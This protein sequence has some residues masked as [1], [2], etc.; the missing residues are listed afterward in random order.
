MGFSRGE[1]VTML[2][3]GTLFILWGWY[4]FWD[5][6]YHDGKSGIQ[7]SWWERVAR[8]WGQLAIL[9]MSLLLL[10]STK[11]SI[12]MQALGITWER[13]LWM[14]RYLGGLC[15]LLMSLHILSYWARFT[16]LKS[17]PYDAFAY[18]QYYS[19]N[20]GLVNPPKPDYDNWTIAIMQLLAYPALFMVGI[21][22]LT[23]RKHWELFKYFHY[24]FLALIPALLLH[25][26]SAWYFLLGGIIFWLVDAAIRFTSVVS[27]AASLMPNGVRT[28]HT[29]GGIIELRM[30]W[31]HPEP[32]QFAWIKVPQV[33]TWEWHPFSLS[34]SPYDGCAQMCIKNMGPDT[35]TDRLYKLGNVASS[36]DIQIDG[37][38]GSP[39]DF[40]SHGALLLIAG[41]IGITQVHSLFRTVSHM[42]ERGV[43]FPVLRSVHI[44]W[45]AQSMDLFSVFHESIAENL[46]H[47]KVEF[48]ATFFCTQADSSEPQFDPN[49]ELK[50]GRPT[51]EHLYDS[52]ISKAGKSTALVQ[53]CGPDSMVLAAAEA[54]R[55]KERIVFDNAAFT[56]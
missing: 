35:F 17:F 49:I 50:T 43:E 18:I 28:H 56:L 11:N 5:H 10:P 16:E 45:I 31:V 42:V 20:H 54:A 34:S 19:I 41:G 25:S 39:P 12:W 33:S 23:R 52:A 48:G 21:S 29:E 30:N 2:L 27:T 7:D 24:V 14:H 47:T 40:G 51:F 22:S 37:P 15:L 38:Y 46:K 9:T 55:G 4:W 3:L 6:N 1:T 36:F 44:V 26:A 53:V 32:G 8:T 13:S